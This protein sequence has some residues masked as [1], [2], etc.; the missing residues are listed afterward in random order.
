M[1][2]E[3]LVVG[4]PSKRAK[5]FLLIIGVAI[6]CLGLFLFLINFGECRECYSYYYRETIK[7]NLFDLMFFW[8][9]AGYSVVAY[10]L[11]PFLDLGLLLSIVGAIV[12]F[13]LKNVSITVTEKRVTG[14]TSFGRRVD[15][16]VDN[17]SAV[18]TGMLKT[19][20]VATS[21]GKI[22]FQGIENRDEIHK[23][24]TDLLVVRQSKPAS[25][26]QIRQQPQ[27]DPVD[28]LEKYKGLL[29]KGVITQEDFDAKKKQLLGL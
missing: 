29:D 17:I 4:Q 28:E 16:P 5:A 2:D 22:K 6:L 8:E 7:R 10:L 18:G 26:E 1:N 23:V 24:I 12:Y 9:P 20:V 13:A 19:I 3:V 25:D 21:S 27:A 11:G 14:T 15:L